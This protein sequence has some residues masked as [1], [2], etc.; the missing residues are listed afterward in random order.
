MSTVNKS[1]RVTL[2]TDAALT[3]SAAVIGDPGTFDCR[4]NTTV[5][6]VI[7]WTKGASATGLTVIVE[8][9]QVKDVWTAAVEVPIALDTSGSI[10]AGVGTATL[11]KMRYTLGTAGR[12]HLPVDCAGMHQLRVKALESGT[13]GGTLSVHASGVQEAM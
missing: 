12:Y 13:P 2:A 11:G 1:K 4:N 5:S 7:D 8:G 3:G 9:T 6:L 10:T